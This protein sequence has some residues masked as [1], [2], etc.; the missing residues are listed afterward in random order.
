LLREV[1]VNFPD[2]INVLHPGWWHRKPARLDV[3]SIWMG[4]NPF[5]P[6]KR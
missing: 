6:K 3:E 5:L 1:L 4:K 2:G